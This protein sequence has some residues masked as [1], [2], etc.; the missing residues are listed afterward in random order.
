[1]CHTNIFRLS[2]SMLVELVKGQVCGPKQKYPEKTKV[3]MET[4]HED[5]HLGT[6]C[7]KAT[8]N[9]TI[10]IHNQCVHDSLHVSYFFAVQQT[11]K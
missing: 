2:E 10:L 5:S 8:M 7:C 9:R 1:M 6:V 3:N 11:L 4:P